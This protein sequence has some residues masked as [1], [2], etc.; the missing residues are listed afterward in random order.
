MVANF[1]RARVWILMA[2]SDLERVTRNFESEDFAA[3]VFR[4]Q[5]AAERLS[6]GLIFLLGIQFK[7]AL[8]PT[9]Y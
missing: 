8:K 1:E 5:T 4:A 2:I 7:K 3:T 9:N 6:K